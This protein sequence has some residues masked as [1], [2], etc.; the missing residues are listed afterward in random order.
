METNIYKNNLYLVF[1]AIAL[2]LIVFSLFNIGNLKYGVEFKG[3]TLVIV[4]TNQSVDP[5]VIQEKLKS[6][7]YA[8]VKI[9][10]F[11]TP[12]GYRLEAEIPNSNEIEYVESIKDILNVYVE[13]LSYKMANNKSYDS[14]YNEI[15]TILDKSSEMSGLSYNKTV[16]NPREYLTQFDSMYKQVRTDYENGIKDTLTKYVSAESFSFQTISPT[17]SLSIISKATNAAIMSAILSIILVFFLFRNIGPSI[18]VLTGAASDITISVGLM[19]L[20]QIPLTLASFSALLGLI[21]YSLDT[22]I[23]LTTNILKKARDETA[24]ESAWKAMHTGVLMTISG[25]LSFGVLF[26]ISW[27]LQIPVYYQ[28]A[29]TMLLGLLGDLFA[30]WGINGVMLL[31]FSKK[32]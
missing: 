22:D 9:D 13:N 11:Q 8:D 15:M 7:G 30:T 27:T 14:D 23:L 6:E 20:F 25:I 24:E 26:Y 1:T 5:V 17:L 18:A 4:D 10:Y 21:G 3:G 16:K 12:Y 31:R 32:G 2:G 29:S 28:I 19:A